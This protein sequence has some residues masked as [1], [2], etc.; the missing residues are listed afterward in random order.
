MTQATKDEMRPGEQLYCSQ[1]GI[2]LKVRVVW[3]GWVDTTESGCGG[4]SGAVCYSRVISAVGS[5]A[6][7]RLINSILMDGRVTIRGR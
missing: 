2:R 6:S 1:V 4:G 7:G 3:L 5:N